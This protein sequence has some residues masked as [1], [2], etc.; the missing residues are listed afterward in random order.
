MNQFLLAIEAKNC[1]ALLRCSPPATRARLDR[2]QL[3]SGCREQIDT[4]QETAAQIRA[5]G[6]K[7]VKVSGQRAEITY[8]GT[9]KLVVIESEGRW[10]IEDL[11]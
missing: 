7:P 5:A 8:L 6:T 2:N 10:Y 3:L 11:L 9:H 4:L 1:E